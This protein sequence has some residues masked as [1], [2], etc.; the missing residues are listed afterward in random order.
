[1][2]G[3]GYTQNTDSSAIILDSQD[4]IIKAGTDKSLINPTNLELKQKNYWEAYAEK[5]K[6]PVQNDPYQE[7]LYKPM[8]S[9]GLGTLSFFGDVGDTLSG[10]IR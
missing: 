10:K 6:K 1:M 7:S 8:I 2:N 9:F 3:I 4:T 5:L